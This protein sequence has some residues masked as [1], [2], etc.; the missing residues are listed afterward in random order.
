L[1]KVSFDTGIKRAH[2][3]G[4]HRQL[5]ATGMDQLKEHI[6]L[7]SIFHYVVGGMLWL[8]SLF[9][10]IH[11]VIGIFLLTAGFSGCSQNQD[12]PVD[13]NEDVSAKIIGG[14]FVA[15]ASLI[16][17][18]GLTIAFFV[19]RAGRKLGRHESRTFC[20]VIAAILC[21]FLPFGT[22]LGVFTIIILSKPETR[23]LF[24]E[25]A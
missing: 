8:F 1:N 24:G 16:I 25:T 11:L 13:F 21:A 5:T 19:I 6:R 14:M 20:L 23:E 12:I 15:I 7:L 18:T 22:V 17:V 10:V 9:P 2:I 3:T 4:E